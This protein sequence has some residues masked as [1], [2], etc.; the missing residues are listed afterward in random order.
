[1]PF[2]K[3]ITTK[4]IIFLILVLIILK[5]LS[6]ITVIALLFFASFVVACSLNPIVD[7]L[8][9]KM[10]RST[11]TSLVLLGTLIISFA[12]F[13]PIIF[14]AVKQVQGFLMILPEKIDLIK[15]FVLNYRFHGHRIPEMMD[16]QSF[17]KSSSPF[18]TGLVNQSINFT[19]NFAQGILFFLAICMIVFYFMADK[20][21]IKNGLIEIFPVEMKEKASDIYENISNKV[22]GYVIAQLL[23]MFA[24]GA[25]TAIGLFLIKVDY[26]LLLGLVTGILDIIPIIGPT[27]ALILCLIMANQMGLIGFILVFVVFLTAQW[28]SNNLIRPVIFG[29]FLDLHPLIIIFALLVS[30]QFL[31]VWGVILAPA[32][33]SLVCVLFDEIY[34]KTINKSD[35]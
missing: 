17:I 29:R 20:S 28:I 7:K 18:A 21:V 27:I 23:N 32:L 9:K 15:D 1:M 30:A 8:E 16:I 12:F 13:V 35:E 4:N 34:I 2:K 26:A 22:G 11:A 24:I 6:Q 19:L 3:Y 25:L 10:K 31:G 14:A 33:A 5:F